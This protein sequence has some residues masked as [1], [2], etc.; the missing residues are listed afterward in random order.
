MDVMSWLAVVSGVISILAFVFAIWVWLR[1]DIKVR[2]LMG[3]L[4][5]VHGIAESAVW[6]THFVHGDDEAA[7][8]SQMERGLGQ[9]MAIRA[10][11]SKYADGNS[12]HRN[13]EFE[14]LIERGIVWTIDRLG[15]LEL[16]REV[17]EVWL[18]T[19]DLEPDLSDR[20]TINVVKRNVA[21]GTRYVYFHPI[22]LPDADRKVLRLRRN[23]GADVPPLADQIQFVSMS[24]K[25]I[26]TPA[27]VIMFFKDDCMYG[28]DLVYQE[29]VLTRVSKRGI[30][31]QEHNHAY[32]GTLVA[33]LRDA[34]NSAP[35]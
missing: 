20:E 31:W 12:D 2:E 17:R 21:S 32:A 11:A 18:L 14:T 34:I 28:T 3:A 26:F 4:Q 27:N 7:R 8:L 22:D 19:H 23:I 1:S 6:N 10:L 25:A 13:T 30:F 29:I 15:R 9:V 16:S 24:D 5:T 33:K 35:A